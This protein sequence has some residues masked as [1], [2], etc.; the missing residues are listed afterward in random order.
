M[1]RYGGLVL[2]IALA[3]IF[4][5]RAALTAPGG[6]NAGRYAN[7]LPGFKF[8]QDARWR[9]LTP[10]VS[11]MADV[12]TVLGQPDEESDFSQF[13]KPYPGD[14]A[15]VS[16]VFT[17]ELN[18]DWQL[19]VYFVKYS[20]CECPNLQKTRGDLLFS[21]ELLPK[22]PLSFKQVTFPPVFKPQAVTAVDA[23]WNEFSDGTGLAYEIY[24][25]KTPYGHEQPGDLNRIVY[26][27]LP[28]EVA[29]AEAAAHPKS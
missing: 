16:P 19:L 22:K 10:L 3:S 26:G 8:Y 27:P 1:K 15:A 29:R 25:S 13:T 14:T 21:L 5:P 17:Y 23:R 11:T 28:D 24:T 12:R 18:S 2:T 6:E 4:T 20:M 9:S 7:E